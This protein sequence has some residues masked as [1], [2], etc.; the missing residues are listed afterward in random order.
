MKGLTDNKGDGITDTITKN[1][2][3]QKT[4]AKTLDG[5]NE[6]VRH[7]QWGRPCDHQT[8]VETVKKEKKKRIFKRKAMKVMKPTFA[9]EKQIE[10]KMRYLMEHPAVCSPSFRDFGQTQLS[11]LS[12]V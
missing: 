11:V 1:E 8:Q 7:L 5:I 3:L 10:E 12:G 2:E 6:A 9:V 4:L